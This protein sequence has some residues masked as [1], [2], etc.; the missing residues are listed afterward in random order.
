MEYDTLTNILKVNK[1]IFL[2]TKCKEAF[3]NIVRSFISKSK[4]VDIQSNWIIQ[5]DRVNKKERQHFYSFQRKDLVIYSLGTCS[6]GLK[7]IIIEPNTAYVNLLKEE[8]TL[9]NVLKN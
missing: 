7:N 1:E 4:C 9:E 6:F 2:R 8:Y 3:D 5:I